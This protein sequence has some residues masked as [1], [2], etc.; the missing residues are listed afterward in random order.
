METIAG[1]SEPVA[2]ADATGTA[3]AGAYD[4]KS[5]LSER[6]RKRA[7]DRVIIWAIRIGSLGLFL[8]SWSFI[9]GHQIMD[10]TLVS[11]P[12]AVADAF[13]TQLSD[14]SFWVDV[15][16]TFTGAM[17]GLI[18]GSIAGILAGVVF[19]RV[20]VLERAAAPFLTLMNSL[21]RPA[22]APIFI[23]WFGL[24]TAPKVLVAFSVVFFVLMTNTMSGMRG[25]DH[26][27]SQLARSLG[28]SGRARFLKI[29]F[30][31]ALPTIVGGLRLGAVYSVLG[32]VVAEMVG[33]F[34]G[35]GQRLVVVTN[36]FQ[37]AET[38]AIL[39]AMGLLSMA[40]DYAISGLQRLVTR[41]AR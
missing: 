25:I 1:A 37:V 31:S 17:A 41:R 7:R 10:P 12:R 11:S 19:A 29:E 23:L 4:D 36:N 27:I 34:H 33:A 2:P 28:M 14:G 5:M 3:V 30:P 26:D 20:S 8:Y 16:A 22:L 9:S 40:L 13:I 24:G 39:V 15:N 35:L 32:A 21:P 18:S 38:F 6:G